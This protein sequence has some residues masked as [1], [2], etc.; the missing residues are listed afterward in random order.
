MKKLLNGRSEAAR[1][2]NAH[3]HIYAL[4]GLI[5]AV[6]GRLEDALREVDVVR[7]LPAYT[8]DDFLSS[9]SRWV[10]RNS[11]TKTAARRIGIS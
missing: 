7:R 6:A 2:P 10:A 8:I 3:V 5:L 4:S 9:I 1:K 11:H